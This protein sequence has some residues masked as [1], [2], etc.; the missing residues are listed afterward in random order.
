MNKKINKTETQRLMNYLFKAR[1]FIYK[2]EEKYGVDEIIVDKGHAQNVLD[3]CL[4]VI[5]YTIN[6]SIQID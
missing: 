4:P 2:L 3:S 5:E 1:N 6:N